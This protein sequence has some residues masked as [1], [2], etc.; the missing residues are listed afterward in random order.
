M[1]TTRRAVRKGRLSPVKEFRHS[2]LSRQADRVGSW[3]AGASGLQPWLYTSRDRG[4][5]NWS[6]DPTAAVCRDG[7]ASAQRRKYLSSLPQRTRA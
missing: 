3:G 4:E 7:D 1:S 2:S 5:M 6:P